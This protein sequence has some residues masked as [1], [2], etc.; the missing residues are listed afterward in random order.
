MSKVQEICRSKPD[1]VQE[2]SKMLTSHPALLTHSLKV[3]LMVGRIIGTLPDDALTGQEVKNL[4]TAAIL[5][6][7]G[8]SNWKK[9]WFI[10]PRHILKDNEWIQMQEH[11]IEG[12]RLLQSLQVLPEEVLRI[13]AQHHERSEGRGYPY[14]IEPDL[15]VT[16][17]A[18]CDVYAACTEERPYRANSYTKEAALSQLAMFTP[19]I[20]I[21]AFEKLFN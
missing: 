4:L 5:H 15:L 14:G 7:V 11:P 1:Y 10:K 9:D 18:A 19:T 17:L 3:F 2:I 20:I 6:D 8:K 12:S 13:V 16:I 21:D